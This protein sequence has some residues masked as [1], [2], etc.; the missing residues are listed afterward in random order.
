M[1]SVFAQ[2]EVAIRSL[3]RS[4][5]TPA[6]RRWRFRQW[7]FSLWGSSSTRPTRRNVR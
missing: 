6:T 2:Y 3:N 1:S 4:L 5:V 7:S